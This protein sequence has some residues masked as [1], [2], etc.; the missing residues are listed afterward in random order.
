MDML[1]SGH[2]LILLHIPNDSINSSKFDLFLKVHFQIPKVVYID[3]KILS[4]N[5]IKLSSIFSDF[6]LR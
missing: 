1:K 2:F 4:L 6:K 3:P 5:H